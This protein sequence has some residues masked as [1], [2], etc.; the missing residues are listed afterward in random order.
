MFPKPI[1]P[2][3]IA[4]RVEM[5]MGHSTPCWIYKGRADTGIRYPSISVNN[6]DEKV[7]R[8]SY[9][10]FVGPIPDGLQ[11]DHL[12][13]QRACFNPAHLEPVTQAE[14]N[15]RAVPHRKPV[16]PRGP[17][18][19]RTVA[20]YPLCRKGHPMFGPNLRV[21][22]NGSHLCKQCQRETMQL[23]RHARRVAA[24]ALIEADGWQTIW[25]ASHCAGN[26][27]NSNFHDERNA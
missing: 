3:L 18:G 19:L 4:A 12:C 25:P 11:L 9:V 23:I 7:H 5:D 24:A 10:E 22:R 27:L 16:K 26:V 15:R 2:R 17:R 14:N 8:V 20:A 21:H 6:R 1:R 13:R